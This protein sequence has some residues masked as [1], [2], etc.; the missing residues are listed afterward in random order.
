M[1]EKRKLSLAVWIFIG[2]VAGIIVGLLFMRN[3]VA[4]EKYIKPFG[5]LFMNLIKFIVVPIVLFSIMAGVMSLGDIKKVGSIGLKTIVFYL[6]TTSIA[7]TIGL[8]LANLF[9]GTFI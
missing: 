5:T 7:V 2:L 1:K 4:A 3:P 6:C 8:L 9:K